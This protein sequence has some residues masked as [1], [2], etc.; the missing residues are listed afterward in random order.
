MGRFTQ[1]IPA[2]GAKGCLRCHAKLLS[3]VD[4]R[5]RPKAVRMRYR[6]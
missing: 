2:V 6:R 3:L 4:D 5:V 1:L